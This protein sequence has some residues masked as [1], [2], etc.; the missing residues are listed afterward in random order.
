VQLRWNENHRISTL[1][2]TNHVLLGSQTRRGTLREACEHPGQ[3]PR[4][5]FRDLGRRELEKNDADDFAW[6]VGCRCCALLL[7]TDEMLC[8]AL[9]ARGHRARNEEFNERRLYSIK[10]RTAYTA[11]GFWH[12]DENTV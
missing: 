10:F 6:A 1:S 5:I 11:S 8:G 3:S 12:A 4:H 2:K 7:E 9:E